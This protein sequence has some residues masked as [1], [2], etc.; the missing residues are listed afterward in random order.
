M[1]GEI[2]KWYDVYI[3]AKAN[4]KLYKI[5]T[6]LKTARLFSIVA[7]QKSIFFDSTELVY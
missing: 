7:S 2:C 5:V 4:S 6:R 3:I 1:D